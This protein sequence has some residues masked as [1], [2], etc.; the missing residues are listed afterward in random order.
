MAKL[1][2]TTYALL[3]LLSKRP[4]SAY[5]LAQYM[6]YSAIRVV[7]PRAESGIFREPKKL[8]AEGLAT[9]KREQ[10]NNRLRAVYHITDEGRIAFERWLQLPSQ[11]ASIEHESMLKLLQMNAETPG[12]LVDKI[13]QMAE[14]SREHNVA[15]KQGLE[16]VVSKG[17]TIEGRGIQSLLANIYFQKMSRALLDWTAV[18]QQIVDEAPENMNE[19]E[20]DEWAFKRYCKLLEDGPLWSETD[21]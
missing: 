12:Q 10:V 18:A 8:V 5:E 1:T 9:V 2:S 13:N 3:G 7:W 11:P 17:F 16:T 4:W 19:Q 15:M 21:K 20:S 6:Q 14:E